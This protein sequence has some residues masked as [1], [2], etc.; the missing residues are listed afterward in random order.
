MILKQ[1][2]DF[3]IGSYELKNWIFSTSNT[4][5]ACNYLMKNNV[6]PAESNQEKVLGPKRKCFKVSS[7]D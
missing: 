7:R 6:L 5:P 2:K 3:L 4:K 1:P